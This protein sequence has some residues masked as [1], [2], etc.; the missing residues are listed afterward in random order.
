MFSFFYRSKSDFQR[1]QTLTELLQYRLSCSLRDYQRPINFLCT[2]TA[3]VDFHFQLPDCRHLSCWQPAFKQSHTLIPTRKQRNFHPHHFICISLQRTVH[4]S[5]PGTTG[6]FPE[7]QSEKTKPDHLNAQSSAFTDN[8][9]NAF[10]NA[11][12]RHPASNCCHHDW[13]YICRRLLRTTSCAQIRAITYCP[14]NLRNA[15]GRT[16]NLWMARHACQ[17]MDTLGIQLS[18][19]RLFWQQICHG[20]NFSKQLICNPKQTFELIHP[21][22]AL[23]AERHYLERYAHFNIT[24]ISAFT[25]HLFSIFFQL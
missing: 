15:T 17:Q 1:Q 4:S 11:L 6:I 2:K 3:T 14:N 24:D 16:T 21:N 22:K 12:E 8:G 9:E 7:Q 5:H 19:C 18:G 13:P 10:R 20:T 25:H 23:I